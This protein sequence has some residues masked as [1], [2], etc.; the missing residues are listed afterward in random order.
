MILI[1]PVRACTNLQVYFRRNVPYFIQGGAGWCDS[2]VFYIDIPLK[3]VQLKH[4]LHETLPK[5]LAWRT[6]SVLYNNNNI[7]SQFNVMFWGENTSIG[8]QRQ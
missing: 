5:C 6:I 1:P 2:N 3:K 8:C 4:T 7:R